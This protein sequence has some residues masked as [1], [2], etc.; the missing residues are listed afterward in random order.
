MFF[1]IILT[2]ECNS[3]C[4]YCF[5]ETLKDMDDDFGGINIDYTL[6]QKMAY[7]VSLALSTQK[8]LKERELKG[9]I[10]KAKKIKEKSG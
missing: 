5:G 8:K 1:H 6:P 10:E 4:V 2:G 3:E 7:A 9:Y